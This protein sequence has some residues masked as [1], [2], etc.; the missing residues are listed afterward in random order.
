MFR[1]QSVLVV[2][3]CSIRAT[4]HDPNPVSN[5]GDH[6][7]VK[8]PSYMNYPQIAVEPAADIENGVRRGLFHT[9]VPVSDDL[10]ARIIAGG[11][12]SIRTARD[13]KGILRTL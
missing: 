9:G 6:P 2:D 11:I 3:I 13:V 5:V 4:R 1:K 7:F 10:L 12:A 8:Q